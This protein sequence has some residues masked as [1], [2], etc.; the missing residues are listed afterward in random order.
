[1]HH[2]A[3]L[4]NFATLVLKLNV[5]LKFHLHLPAAILHFSCTD[6]SIGK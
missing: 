3:P 4:S 6:E 1:M 2:L 5:N